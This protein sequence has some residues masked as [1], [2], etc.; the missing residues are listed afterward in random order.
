MGAGLHGGRAWLQ[1]PR[2]LASR[3][4]GN[5]CRPERWGRAEMG[6]VLSSLQD[7][8]TCPWNSRN[9]VS[10]PP[11]LVEGVPEGGA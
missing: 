4:H 5:H 7:N 9:L 2:P 11:E 8:H 6:G 10:N 1:T 3:S